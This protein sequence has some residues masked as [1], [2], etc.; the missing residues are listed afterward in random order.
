MEFTKPDFYDKIEQKE[1]E[2][3]QSMKSFALNEVT[4]TEPAFAAAR[5]SDVAFIKRLDPDRLLSAFRRSAGLPDQGKDPYGGW[6]D[7]RIGGHT[8]GHYLVACAQEIAATGDEGLRERVDT[9]IE[10]LAKCQEAHGNGFLFGAKLDPGE[11]P[12]RQFDIE[13]GK[14]HMEG[15]LITWVPWYTMHKIFDGLLAVYRFCGNQKALEVAERLGDWVVQRVGK[16]SDATRRLVLGKEYGGMNDCLYQ[17]WHAS[18]REQYRKAAEIFDDTELMERLIADQPDTMAGQHANTTIPKFLGGMEQHPQ[19][20]EGFWDRVTERHAYATGGISDMEHFHEDYG[21]DARRTQCN[22]EGCCAH[23]MLKLS[24]RLYSRTP[25]KKY[26]EYAERLL[27][28]AILGAIDPANGTTAYFS[29]MATGYQKTFSKED[30]EENKFWCCTGTG[31]ENY[32][33]LQDEIYFTEGKGIWVNQYISSELKSEGRVL[34]LDMS[35]KEDVKA[36]LSYEGVPSVFALYL[37]LPSWAETTPHLECYGA[38]K[39]IIWQEDYVM[40]SGQWRAGDTVSLSFEVEV[41]TQALPDQEKAVCF[42]YGPFV[43]AAKL[44]RAHSNEKTGAGIDVVADAW[45]VVGK[46]EANLVIEYGETHRKI[47]DTETLHRKNT[48]ESRMDFL[49]NIRLYMKRLPGEAL[50]FELTGTDGAEI[51]GHPM[52]F[53]P[54]YEITDERYGIYWYMED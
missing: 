48:Q 14:L 40:L 41:Q 44:G 45:K 1:S 11:Q 5:E 47:L 20:A 27:F 34:R 37:R 26:V 52:I 9:V 16:W 33:K 49:E 42:T 6:E 13:E 15:F 53:V 8:M 3:E 39:E 12:E 30:L 22:C 18:G 21:L 31:M 46:E 25:R 4:I 38:E 35:W 29:P 24:H 50:Q 23:N 36:T 2:G 7:S 17:L 54:Y 19:L 43:L 28:N 10:E 32:T 51:L